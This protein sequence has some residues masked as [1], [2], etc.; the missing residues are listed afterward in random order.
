[1]FDWVS[2]LT[3]TFELSLDLGRIRSAFE[4]AHRNASS[5][6]PS[7]YIEDYC[8]AFPVLSWVDDMPGTEEARAAGLYLRRTMVGDYVELSGKD[9]VL[10]AYGPPELRAGDIC[11]CRW[12]VASDEV[13][14]ILRKTGLS[15]FRLIGL[16]NSV[17][18]V[19]HPA[20]ADACSYSKM[21]VH[22][23]AIELQVFAILYRHAHNESSNPNV[24]NKLINQDIPGLQW[25][26]YAVEGKECH[27]TELDA[28]QHNS[29]AQQ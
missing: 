16:A 24:I 29:I 1:M 12:R 6:D 25:S 14:L 4:V 3:D 18:P 9:G 8:D 19:Y 7:P 22:W 23:H 11:L 17:V 27:C 10:C 5:S 2:K 26:S 13:Y 15:R 21:H 28:V 20:I